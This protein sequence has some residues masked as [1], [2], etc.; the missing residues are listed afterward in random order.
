[1]DGKLEYNKKQILADLFE[2][3]FDCLSSVTIVD[4]INDIQTLEDDPE[5][6]NWILRNRF[7]LMCFEHNDMATSLDFLVFINKNL[8]EL[9]LQFQCFGNSSFLFKKKTLNLPIVTFTYEK[10]K[11]FLDQMLEWAD[12]VLVTELKQYFKDTIFEFE[13]YNVEGS[14]TEISLFSNS[15]ASGLLEKD[16]NIGQT[17]K[18]I[19]KLR[20]EYINSD[21]KENIDFSPENILISIPVNVSFTDN[22]VNIAYEDSFWSIPKETFYEEYK[23]KDEVMEYNISYATWDIC[24]V[25]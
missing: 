10:N 23:N 21:L 14:K 22:F 13:D 25:E 4:S 7:P 6:T 11:R 17:K 5:K 9:Y 16:I 1:M 18:I 8:N 19:I 24:E 2:D 20:R 3:K 12:T 15:E